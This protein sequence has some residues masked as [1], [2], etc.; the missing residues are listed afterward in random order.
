MTVHTYI[1]TYVNT[2]IQSQILISVLN[3]G[4]ALLQLMRNART[5]EDSF[6]IVWGKSTYFRGKNWE[7]G[8][9]VVI[10]FGRDI[11]I[12]ILMDGQPSIQL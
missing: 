5:Y 10:L 2:Y 3:A 1:P 11:S 12:R 9:H 4:H 8:N 6:T 7:V